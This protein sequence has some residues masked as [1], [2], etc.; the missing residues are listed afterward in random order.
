MNDQIEKHNTHQS[1]ETL[2]R[3]GNTNI[4]TNLNESVFSRMDV[5]LINYEANISH[6]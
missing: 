6:T 5:N 1:S 4:R 2:I 3:S